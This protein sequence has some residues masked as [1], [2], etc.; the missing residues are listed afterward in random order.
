LYICVL[1]SNI[2]WPYIHEFLSDILA[3]RK[4]YGK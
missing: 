2:S 1:L 3:S 4:C